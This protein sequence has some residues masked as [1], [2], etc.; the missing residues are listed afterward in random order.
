LSEYVVDASVAVKWFIPE[1]HSEAAWRL[2]NTESRL[3]VPAFF[4]L[5]VGNTFCKKVRRREIAP[6]VAD[7]VLRELHRLPLQRHPDE[8][9]FAPAFKLATHTKRSLYD[10]LYLA[11]AMMLG[12]RLVTADRPFF[13]ALDRS[14]LAT[15]LCWVEEV[16]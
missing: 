16:P 14:P 11:L 2:R 13:K 9:L 1:I 8:L 4:T 15:H 12:G 6:D 10:C 5:E 3:H 7:A